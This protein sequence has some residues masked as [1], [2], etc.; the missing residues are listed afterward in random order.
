MTTFPSLI[1]SCNP[2]LSLSL[3]LFTLSAC[4]PD[5]LPEPAVHVSGP[6]VNGDSFIEAS[7][8]DASR[9]N[10]LLATDSASGRV[11]DL[12]F[13]GLVKYDKDL[14]LVGDLAKS[15]EVRRG[16]LEIVFHLRSGV[17]WHDGVPFTSKDVLFTYQKLKDHHVKTPFGADFESV[18]SVETPD[19]LTVRVTYKEPF[20]PALES[21]GMGVI[22]EHLLKDGDFNTSPVHRHPVGTGPYR[23]SQ[24]VTDEKI[25]LTA[26]ENYFDGRP[27]LDRVIVRVI[28]DNAVQFLE[29]RNQSIDSMGLSPD[30]YKAYPEFFTHYQKFRTPSQSYTYFAF[31][32]ENDLFKDPLVRE[33]LDCSVDKRDIIEGVLL[34]FGREATG[35]FVPQSWAY[36]PDVKG[37]AYDPARARDLLTKAGWRDTDGDGVLDKNGRPFHFTCLTNQG[38]KQRELTVT[39]LQSQFAKVGVAMDIRVLEWS[40]FIHNF[41]EPRKFEAILLGWNLGRDPDPYALWHSSQRGEGKYNFTGYNNPESDRLLMEGRQTFDVA[42][43]QEIYHRFHRQLAEQRPYLFL[44]YA[45]A[46]PVVHQRFQ[47][48]SVAPAGI[49]W[50]FREWYVPTPFQKYR[51]ASSLTL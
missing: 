5:P 27:R 3:C 40:S 26:N 9:L 29:L 8:G 48:V 37:T 19:P 49:G 47:G 7:L 21:W 22:P 4:T 15:F 11:N 34:G 46:L 10:P 42:K 32:L 12:L 44:Y 30:Q 35:P 45:E 20:A 6:A 23:F 28:P 39:I 50:N 16:G 41:V 1:R 43:R 24:W 38:N 2:S 17:L 36:D 13:S 25:V 14:H 18:E 33:A 51:S 31:N